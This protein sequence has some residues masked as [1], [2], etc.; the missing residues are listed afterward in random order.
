[1]TTDTPDFSRGLLLHVLRHAGWGDTTNGGISVHNDYLALVGTMVDHEPDTLK[2]LPADSRVFPPVE[3]RPAVIL[4]R[5]RV[6]QIVTFHLRPYGTEPL[7]R[8][9]MAGGNYA[10]GDSRFGSLMNTLSPAVEIH[11]RCET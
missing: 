6:G 10:T 8:W 3:G 1:M 5:R 7:S 4:V 11:D 2:P 9:F